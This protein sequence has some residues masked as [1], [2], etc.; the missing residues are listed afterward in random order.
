MPL[1]HGRVE[2]RP[3]G[4]ARLCADKGG[5]RKERSNHAT[6]RHYQDR[7]LGCFFQPRLL[8]VTGLT[9][10]EKTLDNFRE[11]LTRPS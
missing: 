8:R 10:G 4:K 11:T 3:M 1:I 7:G 6:H 9:L 5:E 2:K